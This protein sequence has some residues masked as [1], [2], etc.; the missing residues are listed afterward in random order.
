MP[1]LSQYDSSDEYYSTLFHELGHS[2]GHKDRLNR[3]G[4]ADITFFGDHEYSKE[5]LVAEI[6]ASMLVSQASLAAERAF[7]NSVAYLQSWLRA[8]KDDSKIIVWAAGK[9]E[10]AARFILGES[11]SPLTTF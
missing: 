10:A 9:A 5:E 3:K 7:K 8:L 11:C 1:V 2:T 6:T 4:V